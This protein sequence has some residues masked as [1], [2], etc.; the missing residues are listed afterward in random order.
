MYIFK[1]TLLLFVLLNISY[2]K[3]QKEL[4]NIVSVQWLKENLNNKR[5]VILDIRSKEEYDKGHIK[6]AINLPGKKYLFTPKTKLMPRLNTLRKTFS[7]V[8]IDNDS[9]VVAYYN[10]DYFLSARLVW[11]LEVLGHKNVGMLEYSYGDFIKNNFQI[12]TQATTANKKS[13]IPMI[14][15]QQ[16]QTKLT[17]LLSIGKKTIIDGRAK[18]QYLGLD[19]K[20]KRYGHIPSAKN[21]ACSANYS[22]T[23][24][25][26]KIKSFDKLK[27]IYKD[28]PKDKEVILY[29]QGGA[30]SALNYLILKH[31]GYK[32]SVY[33]GSWQEW[34]NDDSLPIENPSLLKKVK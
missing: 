31:F 20:S 32:V 18:D 24:V 2:A 29:C 9:L 27:D 33:D 15:S 4:Q 14:D 11:I 13:F 25:G 1:I 34:G 16:I 21:Y 12:E 26:T 30:E 3:E 5:L 8:G 7:N 6:G 23:K 22:K 17:T 10:E 28:I 19:S